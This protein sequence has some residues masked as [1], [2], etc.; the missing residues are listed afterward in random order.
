M[1]HILH[2]HSAV[3]SSSRSGV[4]LARGVQTWSNKLL[5]AFGRVVQ[6]HLGCVRVCFLALLR[7]ILLVARL[8]V[9]IGFILVAMRPTHD[10][11]RLD[12]W[13]ALMVDIVALAVRR[14]AALILARVHLLGLRQASPTRR[15][16]VVHLH[17]I[18]AGLLHIN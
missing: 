15:D 9:H 17:S 8:R 14:A 16:P 7:T 1:S 4:V 5:G 11:R 2:R 13:V 6:A 18:G 10:L 3:R 12:L